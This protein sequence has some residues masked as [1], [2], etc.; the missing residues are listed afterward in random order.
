MKDF[1]AK[2]GEAHEKEGQR[3]SDIAL[4]VR[5]CAVLG[6]SQFSFDNNCEQ[7]MPNFI[8]ATFSTFKSIDKF[9]TG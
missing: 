1:V 3:D 4:K 2:V 6:L 8:F 7:I 5:H 9:R